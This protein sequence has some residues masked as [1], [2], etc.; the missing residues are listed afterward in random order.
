MEKFSIG[1]FRIVAAIVSSGVSDN[2]KYI[3]ILYFNNLLNSFNL[4]MNVKF[5]KV[6]FKQF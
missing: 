4:T 3:F 2:S 6:S 5:E 1:F